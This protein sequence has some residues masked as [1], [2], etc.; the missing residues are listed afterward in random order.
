MVTATALPASASVGVQE[1]VAV[2]G[3]GAVFP[4]TGLSVA[5]AGNPRWVTVRLPPSGSVPVVEMLKGWPT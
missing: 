3:W 1:N 5:P 2:R 4:D